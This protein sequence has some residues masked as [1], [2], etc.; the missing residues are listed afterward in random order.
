[1]D[2]GARRGSVSTDER[3]Q[4]GRK[5]FSAMRKTRAVL[6]LLR[7]ED[8]ET[9][10]RELQVTAVVLSQWRDSFLMGG[11]APMKSRP[12]DERDELVARLQAKVA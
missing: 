5:R 6:R 11:E 4:N 12:M 8:I 7:G 3:N 10:S 1:M 2:R 9:V